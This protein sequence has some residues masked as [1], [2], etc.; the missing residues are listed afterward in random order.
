MKLHPGG[1]AAVVVGVAGA[2]WSARA[3]EVAQDATNL[4]FSA[5][6]KPV[7]VYRH[8]G[9]PFKPYAAQLWTPGGVAVLRDSP[10][11]HKHHH[12]LM[13]A[14]SAD[15]VS[16]WEETPKGGFQLARQLTLITDGLTQQLDWQTPASN[17]VLQETRTL[18]L[19]ECAGAT[20]LTWRSKLATPPGKDAVELTGHHYYGLG[21]RFLQCMDGQGSFINATSKPGDIVRGDERLVPARWAA[22]SAATEGRF[23]TFALFDHPE[24][25]RHPNKLFSMAKPF[26]FLACTLNLWK[27]PLTVKAGTPLDL[28]YGV[29]L[30]DGPADPARLDQLYRQWLGFQ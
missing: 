22:F 10:H 3:F 6:G 2:L 17:L 25:P 1:W 12:A 18:K 20:L 21:A 7:M 13:F 11:D 29:V 5:G 19:H 9:Y 24:N 23:I 15:G 26:G 28:R 4:T 27:E 16:F 30:L 14:V 8:A